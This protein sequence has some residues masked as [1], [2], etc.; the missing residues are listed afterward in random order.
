MKGVYSE[1][2]TEPK[3]INEVYIIR[4]NKDLRRIKRWFKINLQSRGYHKA[5][6]VWAKLSYEHFLLRAFRSMKKPNH[7]EATDN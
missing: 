1:S 6:S 7:Y 3:C 5:A 4:I 2:K